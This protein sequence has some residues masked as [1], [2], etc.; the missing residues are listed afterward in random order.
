[1]H[2]S[3]ISMISDVYY[4]LLWLIAFSLSISKPRKGQKTPENNVRLFLG[5]A[6]LHRCKD[7]TRDFTAGKVFFRTVKFDVAVLATR[8]P[9]RTAHNRPQPRAACRPRHDEPVKPRNRGRVALVHRGSVVFGHSFR[10]SL[11]VTP[12]APVCAAPPDTGTPPAELVGARSQV[13]TRAARCGEP[14]KTPRDNERRA[15]PKPSTAATGIDTNT[16]TI[17]SQVVTDADAAT[18]GA[19]GYLLV[20]ECPSNWVL[21]FEGLRRLFGHIQCTTV[22]ESVRFLPKSDTRYRT[23]QRYLQAVARRD[24]HIIWFCY[25]PVVER[26]TK[27]GICGLPVDTAPN[28]IMAALQEIGFAAEYARPIFTREGR[29]GCLFYTRL[30]LINQDGLQRLYGVNTLLNMPGVTIEG[31]RGRPPPAPNVTTARRSSTHHPTATNCSYAYAAGKVI[32]RPAARDLKRKNQHAAIIKALI[33]RAIRD[34]RPPGFRREARQRGNTIPSPLPN[35]HDPITLHWRNRRGQGVREARQT[36]ATD[37]P[38]PQTLQTTTATQGQP[39]PAMTT[40][41][42]PQNWRDRPEKVIPSEGLAPAESIVERR[43]RRRQRRRRRGRFPLLPSPST[44]CRPTNNSTYACLPTNQA[45]SSATGEGTTSATDEA[46]TITNN[47]HAA[48]DNAT[49]GFATT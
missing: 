41:E 46:T 31:W 43:R 47:N 14:P 20:V 3:M 2:T 27:V 24:S 28:L 12:C 21:H 7:H 5:T 8:F 10:V 45:Q 9:V 11:Q 6:G 36:N 18:Q 15:T 4:V 26:P 29:P 44:I 48:I 19:R 33:Q 34:A 13:E 49:D 30:W 37:N 17:R 40:L 23:V 1:M 32:W 16:T 25:S 22:R 42:L 39:E 38:L 35:E